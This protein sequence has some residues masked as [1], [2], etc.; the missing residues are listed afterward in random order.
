LP[1]CDDSFSE[2]ITGLFGTTRIQK[3]ISSVT[4]LKITHFHFTI[5]VYCSLKHKCIGLSVRKN[6]DIKPSAGFSTPCSQRTL[7]PTLLR[8]IRFDATAYRG[9]WSAHDQAMTASGA[10]SWPAPSRPIAIAAV[11]RCAAAAVAADADTGG[12]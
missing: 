2:T 11:W 10:V 12:W 4:A 9:Q 5:H 8:S 3:I 7:I 6:R 1:T